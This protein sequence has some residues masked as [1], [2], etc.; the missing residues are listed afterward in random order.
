MTGKQP[1]K[2]GHCYMYV[3]FDGMDYGLSFINSIT[4]PPTFLGAYP[5]HFAVFVQCQVLRKY[6]CS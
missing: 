1:I 5:T 4:Q 2:G 3:M 6:M